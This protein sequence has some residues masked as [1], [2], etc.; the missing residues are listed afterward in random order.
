[1]YTTKMRN[2]KPPYRI[3]FF[4]SNRFVQS[5]TILCLITGLMSLTSW[6]G[7][8]YG[9]ENENTESVG[10]PVNMV[11]IKS[12]ANL[13]QQA[14]DEL[15]EMVNHSRALREK[16]LKD[17]YRPGYHFVAPEGICMPFDPNGALF[18]KGRYHLFYIFKKE[19]GRHSWG[20]ASSTDLFHWRHHPVALEPDDK[21]DTIFSG[22][23]FVDKRGVP[24]ITYWGLGEGRGI[25]LATGSGDMLDTWKKSPHNPVI[26]QTDHGLAVTD[27][28]KVYG[29]ADPSAIWVKDGRYYMLTG[30]L[31]VLRE[32]GQKKNMPEHLGDT[33]YLF[34][35]DDMINWE[36]L[37]PFYKSSRKWTRETEDN[38]CPDFF[39]LGDRHMLL[40]I[41]HNLGC[42]YY[43]GRYENDFFYPET[44]GRMTWTDKEFFAPES[45]VDEEGRRIMWAW[46]FDGRSKES[47]EA[48][49]WSGTMSLPRKLW[50]AGDGTLRMNVPKEIE[51][52]RYNHRE[53][54]NLTIPAYSELPLKN[55][56]GNSLELMIEII[57]GNAAQFGVKVCCSPDGREQT[58]VLY[59]TD[60]KSLKID[61]R[62]SSLGEGKKSVESGPFELKQGEPLKLRVFIDKSVVEAFAND[63]QGVMRRIYPTD[64]ESKNV[65]LFAKGGEVTVKSV[66][67]WDISPSNP[68]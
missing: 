40:F 49:G 33:L 19:R 44:H 63:R 5:I 65:V 64:T 47:Q 62:K 68:Y 56:R 13:S 50:L 10:V 53:V 32:F 51:S 60:E 14:G 58:V 22:G 55:I 67:A 46:I 37:H 59:D 30:N 41:S 42:Q 24:V 34:V 4:K 29:A 16:F 31:L 20:H 3:S 36:Y 43:I 54:R 35:S 66:N 25:C 57:P 61:T 1:M 52:L 2:M 17:P 15:D 7:F 48:S 26:L 38:M 27:D 12:S 23:V 8:S 21:D 28:G 45:I 39:P 6:V 18:W 9:S 11:A